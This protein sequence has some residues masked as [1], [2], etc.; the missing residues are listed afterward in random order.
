MGTTRVAVAK[1]NHMAGTSDSDLRVW[2]SNL[3]ERANKING[4]AVIAK[5]TDSGQQSHSNHMN[6][7]RAQCRV[8]GQ[9]PNRQE[10]VACARSAS[11]RRRSF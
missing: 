2:S 3:S 9:K 8:H 11:R 5:P 10:L 1:D 4:L 7:C 6:C